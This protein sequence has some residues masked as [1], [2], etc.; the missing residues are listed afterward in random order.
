MDEL[1]GDRLVILVSEVIIR[2]LFYC[3]MRV[4]IALCR[5]L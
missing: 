4:A 5:A 1:D 2:I 3:L